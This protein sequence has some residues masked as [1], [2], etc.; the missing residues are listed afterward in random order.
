MIVISESIMFFC[1]D[2][3]AVIYGV[4]ALLFFGSLLLRLLDV[5]PGK[6]EPLILD[7]S[8]AAIALLF[9]ATAFVLSPSQ[10]RLILI[11]ISSIIVLPHLVYILR[12]KN[13]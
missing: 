4:I 9:A 11:P 13:I 8:G 5:Y 6:K 10:L 12:N 3:L 2:Y 1:R 7:F